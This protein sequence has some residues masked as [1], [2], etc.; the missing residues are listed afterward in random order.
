MP[1]P[2]Y[3]LPV[4]GT[5]VTT[6]AHE[7]AVQA[8]VGS[9][10]DTI[11]LD[12]FLVTQRRPILIDLEGVLGPVDSVYI[13]INVYFTD[14]S[15]FRSISVSNP[16]VTGIEGNYT[17]FSL[18]GLGYRD[19]G[20]ANTVYL[21]PAAEEYLLATGSSVPGAGRSKMLPLI[22]ITSRIGGWRAAGGLNVEVLSKVSGRGC[23]SDLYDALVNP[24]RNCRLTLIG[25]SITWGMTVS[26]MGATEPRDHAL[27][28]ARNNLTSLSWANLLRMWAAE[29][30]C[31]GEG[32][33]TPNPG[34][35]RYAKS[36]DIS[37]AY[38]TGFSS[39]L[40]VGFVSGR[41]EGSNPNARLRR[42][43]DIP[44]GGRGLFRFFG[45][46]F[47][48]VH[49]IFPDSSYQVWVDG[50]L[51][52]NIV[53]GPVTWSVETT[54]AGLTEAEH[55]VEIRAIGS[56]YFRLE[57]V[58]RT[59]RLTV[60]N[61][62][63]IGTNTWAWR[64]GGDLLST[65]VP[66]DTTHLIVQLG[67]NDRGF[68][69]GPLSP[70]GAE[71]VYNNL[72]SCLDWLAAN[73]PGA[74]V[75]LMAPPYAPNDGAYGGSDDVARAVR[76]VAEVRGVGYIDNH[77]LTYGMQVLGDDWLMDGLHPNDAGHR[78]IY[79]NIVGAV[80]GYASPA[81]APGAALV[82]H[83]HAFADLTS[84]PVPLSTI[85]ALTAAANQLP[86]YTSGSAAAL[87]TLST[88]ARGLLDDADAAAARVTLGLG[89]AAT[90]STADLPISTAVATA[91]SARP[92]SADVAVA[93]DAATDGLADAAAVDAALALKAD[94]SAVDA[95][96]AGREPATQYPVVSSASS[97]LVS[98]QN[99]AQIRF[100]HATP[101]LTIQ[102]QAAGSY[103]SNF[104]CSG[105]PD[106]ASGQVTITAPGG[107]TLR[108]FNGDS[109]STETSVTVG[110]FSLVRAAADSW[111]L[112]A[113]RQFTAAQLGALITSLCGTPTAGVPNAPTLT[114]T[115]WGWVREASVA[116]A[117]GGVSRSYRT[118]YNDALAAAEV[119]RG[120]VNG[121]VTVDPSNGPNQLFTITGATRF[122][123]PSSGLFP[124]S[125][126]IRL[127]MAGSYS[128]TWGDRIRRDVD[129]AAMAPDP[130]P[131]V[132]TL[133]SYF[134]AGGVMRVFPLMPEDSIGIS[135]PTMAQFA[136]FWDPASGARIA[137]AAS[138]ASTIN[139]P[140]MTLL[141]AGG[142]WTYLDSAGASLTLSSANRNYT[143]TESTYLPT[144]VDLDGR[145]AI[146]HLDGGA[147]LRASLS[148]LAQ[149]GNPNP[150]G[151][152]MPYL[153]TL[154]WGA[155]IYLPS[156]GG[157]GPIGGVFRA[158]NS[159]TAQMALM[160]GA[161][162][163][164]GHGRFASGAVRQVSSAADVSANLAVSAAELTMPRGKWVPATFQV[165]VNS[166]D[167]T[168]DTDPPGTT[169]RGEG[170]TMEIWLSNGLDGH[171]VVDI[172][173]YR[174][175]NGLGYR[176]NRSVLG[177]L[178]NA[179]T[180]QDASDVY[181]ARNFV[182]MDPAL[183]YG[184]A[185][186]WQTQQWLRGVA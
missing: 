155:N 136:G 7:A 43:L 64:G 152:A 104:G 166:I 19:A 4:S 94:Q 20:V 35:S 159:N 115:T 124:C 185:L 177:A 70:G 53:G 163:I 36:I 131:G 141:P 89:S 186:W 184:S 65:G 175:A 67:T 75:I 9:L 32:M 84:I 29:T 13:P 142:V 181:T 16:I 86:Y 100:T 61:N 33:T 68:A 45:S 179:T 125:G 41:P 28:D 24:M 110:A 182:S 126:V 99:Y 149:I 72:N 11:S 154:T 161:S 77:G 23:V 48:L 122:V 40:S 51:A 148:G 57:A 76:R 121:E 133:Y 138:A 146:R 39:I 168:A 17:R 79:A 169:V 145:R 180:L 134:V 80:A 176:C 174:G 106:N 147:G 170:A 130:R 118:P 31:G 74:K 158:D 156:G 137:D 92:T 22:T 103:A 150:S 178:Y 95:A 52:A 82:A 63:I 97:N 81:G 105:Y 66:A 112:I 88:F 26:G 172:S 34:E 85:G 10:Y 151:D 73:R 62:G 12:G 71:G 132:D 50:A 140:V 127:R 183:T 160:A 101:T 5:T 87:T 120:S 116:E 144:L 56:R 139:D 14:E 1:A 135:I 91:L 54:V 164:Y 113:G 15:G 165:R 69:G 59:K 153:T 30:A 128:V 114:D 8:V 38:D 107:I 25:D 117:R 90:Y 171:V 167:T 78:A 102:T 111:I 98:G 47:T 143:T 46:D 123:P 162:T 173:S 18:T 6:A 3:T 60:R 108:L 37:P 93:I 55:V 2:I 42:Y 58:R 27:T 157:L 44:G 83:T 49:G 119:D 96:I 21:D 129:D 109:I